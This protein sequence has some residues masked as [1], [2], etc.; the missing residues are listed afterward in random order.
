MSVKMTGVWTRKPEIEFVDKLSMNAAWSLIS[1]HPYTI[2]TIDDFSKEY[3]AIFGADEL[4]ILKASLTGGKFDMIMSPNENWVKGEKVWI[5]P[6]PKEEPI[7]KEGYEWVQTP[8]GKTQQP[9]HKEAG[10]N[11]QQKD[12]L[13][14]I[15]YDH[16][17]EA[18]RI[19][20]KS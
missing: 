2:A 1:K 16:V 13:G 20:S 8:F 18:L 19:W 4:T 6:A 15:V 9:I 7:L 5:P 12:D 11:S 17:L 10:F 3:A 14:S